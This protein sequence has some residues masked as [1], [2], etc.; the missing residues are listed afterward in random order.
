[1]QRV[2]TP[3]AKIIYK[4]LYSVKSTESPDTAMMAS[5]AI[6]GAHTVRL[7][8][9]VGL[10]SYRGVRAFACACEQDAMERAEPDQGRFFLQLV[11]VSVPR[12]L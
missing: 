11:V 9:V 2:M 8:L 10:G 5:I 12:S 6:P 1:M 7:E 4:Q 3:P